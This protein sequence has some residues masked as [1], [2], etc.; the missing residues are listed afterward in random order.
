MGLFD[1]LAGIFGGSGKV[2]LS[3]DRTQ[4]SYYE[5]FVQRVIP[6]LDLFALE[7]RLKT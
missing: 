7:Q 5:T 2:S 1:W 4:K 3:P 6:R